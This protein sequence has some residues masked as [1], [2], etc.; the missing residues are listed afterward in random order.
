[1]VGRLVEQEKVGLHYQ[2]PRQ[3]RTHD[4]ATAHGVRC[5][6]EIAFAKSESGEYSLRLRFKLPAAVLVENVQRAMIGS[7]VRGTSQ[8]VLF[9]DLLRFGELR[10]C[11]QCQLENG[12]IL[13]RRR[14]LW[15]E[16]NRRAF[17]DSNLTG[18]GRCLTQDQRKQC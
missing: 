6:I 1:M 8:L 9:N 7:V 16:P 3:V 18:I 15:K 10:R 14:F 11:R 2:K 5:P 4:P 17:L 12:F 13:R